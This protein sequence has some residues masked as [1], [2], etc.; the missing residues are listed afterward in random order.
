MKKKF[1]FSPAPDGRSGRV[2][3]YFDKKDEDH[4]IDTDWLQSGKLRI[5]VKVKGGK[6]QKVSLVYEIVDTAPVSEADASNAKAAKDF[7]NKTNVPAAAAALAIAESEPAAASA[8]SPAALAV[9]SDS[10]VGGA[11]EED[12]SFYIE[13]PP[14]AIH[15]G[16]KYTLRAHVP[17]GMDGKVHWEIG[18][19]DGG[20]I[21]QNGQYTAPASP[22][23]YEVIARFIPAETG[24]AS[25]SA[26]SA[27]SASAVSAA[28]EAPSDEPLEASVY[29][30]VL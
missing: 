5:K 28:E 17:A 20:T 6:K 30:I 15:C 13:N 25:V 12:D 4:K 22:G 1:D 27:A 29:L 18:E 2:V 24:A 11:A 26:V 21:D 3:F 7:L 16:W 8:A 19:E 14:T 10:L 9:S 23:A